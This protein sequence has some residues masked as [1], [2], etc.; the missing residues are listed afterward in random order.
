MHDTFGSHHPTSFH[1]Q[2]TVF[3][4]D[5]SLPSPDGDDE[6]PGSTLVVV[7]WC[8]EVQ[9]WEKLPSCFDFWFLWVFF[10]KTYCNSCFFSFV[11]LANLVG[12][13]LECARE[14]F[15]SKDALVGRPFVRFHGNFPQKFTQWNLESWISEKWQ[16]TIL[17]GEI[18][19]I[20]HPVIICAFNIKISRTIV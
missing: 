11:W 9:P 18:F 19:S 1:T 10:F 6:F 3:T 2:P 13:K 16:K 14:M 20:G 5:R 17:V 8:W 7:F 12:F 4:V 15:V